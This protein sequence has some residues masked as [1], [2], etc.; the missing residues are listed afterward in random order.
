MSNSTLPSTYHSILIRSYVILSRT[1]FLIVGTLLMTLVSSLCIHP[2]AGDDGC[3]SH[4]DEV[5]R[6]PNDD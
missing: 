3:H 6:R 1:G 4:A 5:N 2:A